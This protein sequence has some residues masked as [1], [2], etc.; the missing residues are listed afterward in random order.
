MVTLFKTLAICF[1][2]SIKKINA[3]VT[4]GALS[5]A[6]CI[7]MVVYLIKHDSVHGKT[8]YYSNHSRKN[9]ITL[10]INIKYDVCRL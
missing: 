4:A 10:K 2:F 7:T 5:L 9:A 6:T 1:V 8:I 3:K